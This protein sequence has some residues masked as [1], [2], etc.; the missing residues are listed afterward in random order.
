MKHLFL[1]LVALCL[2]LSSCSSVPHML[3]SADDTTSITTI[4]T[5]STAPVP[6]E[7]ETDTFAPTTTDSDSSQ[8]PILGVQTDFSQYTPNASPVAM[9]SRL[10]ETPIWDLSPTA[11]PTRIYPF[12]GQT[13]HSPYDYEYHQG[14]LYGIVDETGCILTDPIYSSVYPLRDSCS[15]IILPFWVLRKNH[16]PTYVDGDPYSYTDFLYGLA[17]MDGSFVTEC[18]Y[19]EIVAFGDRIFAFYPIDY[20][21]LYSAAM[22]DVYDLEGHQVLSSNELSFH[23][24]LYNQAW[25]YG[26]GEGL[27]VIPLQKPVSSEDDPDNLSIECDYYYMDEDGTLLLGPYNSAGYFS[28][29]FAAVQPEYDGPYV[30]ID[31][32]GTVRS[33]EYE[34]CN[35]FE[36]DTAIVWETDEYGSIYHLIDSDFRTILSSYEYPTPLFDGS[37]STTTA[38]NWDEAL[39]ATTYCHSPTGKLLWEEKHCEALSASYMLLSASDG[40]STILKNYETGK[41]LTFPQNTSAELLGD[42]EDPIIHIDYVT[43]PEAYTFIQRFYT[44]DLEEIFS[45][46]GFSYFRYL[47]VGQPYQE[48]FPARRE[49]ETTLY[50][51]GSKPLGTYPVSDYEDVQLYPGK[52]AVFTN[53]QWTRFYNEKGELF[54]CYPSGTMDD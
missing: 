12:L 1:L 29:G 45:F 38:Q 33:P 40:K 35:T 44:K 39:D 16:V 24:E 7:T 42:P 48:F 37:Y 31:K 9:Y 32:S 43:D 36:G 53:N 13:I 25:S 17:S 21:D 3:P 54:F 10:S 26:Y 47:E 28:N 30:Y 22:F 11:Q 4:P 46:E 51:S 49:T 27:Y 41:T 8:T 14:Y 19:T 52:V 20:S 6:S 23:T 5:E 18:I 50:W 2:L 15:S 34:H